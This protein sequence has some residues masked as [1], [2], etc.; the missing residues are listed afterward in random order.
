VFPR[1]FLSYSVLSRDHNFDPIHQTGGLGHGPLAR[2][3]SVAPENKIDW[4]QVFLAPPL[5]PLEPVALHARRP[6][7]DAASAA[8]ASGGASDLLAQLTPKL[9][10]P[11][12]DSVASVLEA[13]GLERY[14]HIFTDHQFLPN[15]LFLAT[16]GTSAGCRRLVVAVPYVL[17]G[18]EPRLILFCSLVVYIVLFVG[19]CL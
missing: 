16:D 2:I 5:P 7:P 14:A 11:L 4:P 19:C 3:L 17:P 9:S 10:C 6:G 13:L 12:P 18:R 15:D 1:R 8:G